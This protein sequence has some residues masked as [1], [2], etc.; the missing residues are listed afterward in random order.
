M[1]LQRLRRKLTIRNQVLLVACFVFA[2]LAATEYLVQSRLLLPHFAQIERDQAYAAMDRVSDALGRELES[3][4]TSARDWGNWAETY[5][6]MRGRSA[7]FLDKNVC[8]WI[9]CPPDGWHRTHRCS[10][11]SASAPTS[12]A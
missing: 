2:G 10:A 6:F 8:R 4:A 1:P 7:G 9:S 12:P 5:D 3:F 11:R